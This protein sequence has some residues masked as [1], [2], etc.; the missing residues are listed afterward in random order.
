[1]IGKFL[2][3]ALLICLAI[4]IVMGIITNRR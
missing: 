2:T 3:P 4:L 1:M